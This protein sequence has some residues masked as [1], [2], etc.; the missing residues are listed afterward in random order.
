MRFFVPLAL[1]GATTALAQQTPT[2]LIND[3]L[4]QCLAPCFTTAMEEIS[5]CNDLN[6]V[7]CVCKA[8]ALNTDNLSDIQDDINSCAKNCTKD[9][10]Q[11]LAGLD[12]DSLQ[13]Q[14]EGLCSAAP[15]LTAT[16]AVFAA[17]AMVFFAFL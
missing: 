16:N 10:L 8:G 7:D 5:G 2:E 1:L 11:Q 4:P 17:G 9:E 12:F 6:D 3:A 14:A 15:I 13:S